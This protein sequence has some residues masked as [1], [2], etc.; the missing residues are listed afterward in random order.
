MSATPSHPN[1]DHTIEHD[2]HAYGDQS[3]PHEEDLAHSGLGSTFI[4]DGEHDDESSSAPE[5]IIIDRVM[6][7]VVISTAPAVDL[8]AL[9]DIHSTHEPHADTQHDIVTVD[10][11]LDS[12]SESDIRT[13]KHIE[14]YHD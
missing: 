10:L 6:S 8:D 3:H 14:V 13:Q 2:D 9:R 4:H 1:H 7:D 12:L 5:P 11:S